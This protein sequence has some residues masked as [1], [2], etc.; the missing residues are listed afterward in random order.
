MR[1]L[2]GWDRYDSVEA[3]N[4]INDL[5][6]KLRIFQ[7]LFQPSMRLDSKIRKGSRRKGAVLEK[8]PLTARRSRP[9]LEHPASHGSLA[10]K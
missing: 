8:A 3:L 1:K 10:E 5:Y 9:V 6:L 7:N 2:L 4:I